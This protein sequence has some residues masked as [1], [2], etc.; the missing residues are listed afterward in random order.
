[1][2]HGR[3]C[4]RSAAQHADCCGCFGGGRH[5]LGRLVRGGDRERSMWDVEFEGGLLARPGACQL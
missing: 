2:S 1:L 5:D 4:G 3:C